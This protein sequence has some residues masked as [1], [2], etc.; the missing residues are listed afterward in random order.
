MLEML[1]C[2]LG[3]FVI[4]AFGCLDE[5]YRNYSGWWFFPTHLKN[6][7]VKLGSSSPI[8]GVKIPKI[9]ELPPSSILSKLVYHLFVGGELTNHLE[10]L[11]LTTYKLYDP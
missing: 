1:E 5:T 7:L 6:M 8:F 10:K 3:A 11:E 2:E 9:F 4:G